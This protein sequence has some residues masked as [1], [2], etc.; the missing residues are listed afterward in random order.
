MYCTPVGP[1][2]QGLGP[3]RAVNCCDTDFKLVRTDN[4]HVIHYENCVIGR[5]RLLACI[6]TTVEMFWT[7]RPLRDF[8]KYYSFNKNKFYLFTKQTKFFCDQS[9]STR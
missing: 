7:Y 4:G 1:L 6:I 2:G 8:G 9:P 5:A 3:Y